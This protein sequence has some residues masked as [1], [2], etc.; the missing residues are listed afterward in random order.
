[1]SGQQEMEVPPL[2]EQRPEQQYL[3][4]SFLELS[5]T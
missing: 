4:F 2:S 3:V 1:M 5:S